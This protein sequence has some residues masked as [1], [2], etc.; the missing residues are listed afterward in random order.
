MMPSRDV[1]RDLLP[2][3]AA[4]EASADTVR[5]VEQ[6]MAADPVLAAEA[7]AFRRADPGAV[8]G[9]SPSQD[10]DRAALARIRSVVRLRSLLMG[11]AIFLTLMPFSFLYG[12]GQL[13]LFALRDAPGMAIPALVGGGVCWVAYAMLGRRLARG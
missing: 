11:F 10:R 8:P 3:Y 4:G 5:L 12:E 6:A 9:V 2:L 1:V 7:D 13:K